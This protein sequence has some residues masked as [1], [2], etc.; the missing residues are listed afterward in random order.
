MIRKLAICI[1]LAVMPA[2][3]SAQDVIAWYGS[4]GEC[5]QAVQAMFNGEW[6]EQKRTDGAGA[7]RGR[8]FDMNPF[9]CRSVRGRWAIVY[10]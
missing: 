1:G 6:K 2:A 10:R 5:Q 8:S 9:I 7:D 4:L 3:A